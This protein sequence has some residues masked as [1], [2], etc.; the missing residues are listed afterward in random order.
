MGAG[1]SANEQSAKAAKAAKALQRKADWAGRVSGNYA[2]GAVGEAMVAAALEPLEAL[3]WRVLHDLRDPAGGNIDHIA[4]GPPGIAVLDAK[5]WASSVTVTGTRLVADGRDRSKA[6]DHLTEMVERV[7]VATA[8]G[9]HRLSLRGYLVLTGENDRGRPS[10]DL[11]DLRVI[12]VD[13]LADRLSGVGGRLTPDD[14]GAVAQTLTNVMPPFGASVTEGE[15][16]HVEVE[17]RSPSELFERYHRFFYLNSWRKA[18]HH[19]MYLRDQQG[20]S[21]GWTDLNTHA[22]SIECEGDQ[23]RFAEALLAAAD[24]TGVKLAPGDLP[25]VAGRLW[26]GRLLSR[27]ARMHTAV[28]VGQEWRMYGKHRLYGH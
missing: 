9:G 4:I 3:G 11:G 26:G 24:P 8:D 19:R 10:D 18:G 6:L 1:G 2:K 17:A 21:L 13:H 27:I 25:K 15:V 7:R 16:S 28:L 12:G 14:V 23:A 20:N 22:T 5:N